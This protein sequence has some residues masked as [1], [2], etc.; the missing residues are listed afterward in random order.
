MAEYVGSTE[1]SLR[2]F[3]PEN[4][5]SLAELAH[6]GEKGE[7]DMGVCV[8]YHRVKVA[9]TVADL[10][11]RVRAAQIV[12]D[13]FVI[14]VDQY[15]GALA[16]GVAGL[17]DDC[18]KTACDVVRI[19]ARDP[20]V[21][22]VPAQ[23]G[24]DAAIEF[25]PAL[26]DAATEAEADHRK[27]PSPVPLSVRMKPAEQRLVAGEQFTQGIQEQRL[28]EAPRTRQEVMGA[29]VDQAQ[30][31][32]CLVDVVTVVFAQF[33]EGLDTDGQLS[34]RHWVGLSR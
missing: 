33:R 22:T 19:S 29:F 11:G 1:M 25:C 13:G 32:A 26:H 24:A 8:L 7:A 15:H 34:P 2:L 28:T 10:A 4:R 18:G 3:S 31:K 14:F 16:G 17:F 5:L 12:E 30:R 21:V 9:Q 23:L 6:A 20:K 27:A